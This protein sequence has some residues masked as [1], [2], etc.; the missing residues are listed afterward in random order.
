MAELSTLARPYAKAAFE[1]ADAAGDLQGWSDSLATAA[2]VA[3]QAAVIKLLASPS[4][5]AAQQAKAF[6]DVCGDSKKGRHISFGEIVP[7][8]KINPKDKS[9]QQALSFFSTLSKRILS[10]STVPERLWLR[11]PPE[12]LSPGI[13]TR[14][15]KCPNPLRNATVPFPMGSVSRRGNAARMIWTAAKRNAVGCT[16]WAGLS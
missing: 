6:I 5:T 16:T 14:P 15:W 1:Y 4:Y 11:P 10:P 3:A 13:Q 8:S 2:Q 12:R 9:Q 7:S